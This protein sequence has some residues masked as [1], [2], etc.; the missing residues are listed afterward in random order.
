MTSKYFFT[1]AL[2]GG[3]ASLASLAQVGC[4]GSSGNTATGGGTTS[5][6]TL[7]HTTST[8]S[9]TATGGGGAGGGSTGH[10][11]ST[12]TPI[13]ENSS[14]MA[15]L[16]DA[17]TSDWYTFDGKAGDRLYLAAQATQLQTEKTGF[18]ATVTQTTMVLTGADMNVMMPLTYQA[19]EWPQFGQDAI[20]Y[21][22]LPADGAY[23]LGVQDCNGLFSSGCNP[24]A[25]ITS[26]D[27][28]L[29]VALTSKL[30]VP[31][32]VAAATNTG[33]TANADTLT[34]KVASGTQYYPS[35]FGGDFPASAGATQVFSFTPPTAS[36]AAA[37]ARSRAEFYVQP[38]GSFQG[39]DLSAA[40]VTIWA[41]DSSG[42]KIISQA[43]QVNYPTSSTAY[44]PLEFSLPY[45][46]GNQYYIF[47]KDDATPASAMTDFYFIDHYL[48]PLI[49]VAE[50]ECPTCQGTNDTPAT[51]QGLTGQ[52][53][54]KTLFTVDG[55]I[56]APATASK[57][58][59]DW[60]SFPVPNG[61]TQY[62][63]QCDSM[64]TGSGVGGFEI[65]LFS[66]AAAMA[67]PIGAN[68]ASATETP[69]TD[70]SSGNYAA[71]PSGVTTGSTMYMQL[72]GA[73]QSA[74]VTGTQY[75]CYVFFQ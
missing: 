72:T 75:R 36:A 39:G 6:H 62:A 21:V 64:R 7:T 68:F 10:D 69:T 50:A 31:E 25:D 9:A 52:G 46:A 71:L 2:I 8:T 34:Y 58:D 53:T 43:D 26:F 47:V 65:Q 12:A 48:N 41:T 28:T 5:T 54:T 23:Y 73:T 15:T 42:T 4:G 44:T 14:T 55:S 61:V 3:G 57:P 29:T 17:M 30:T 13:V 16:V 27:Y 51:A 19:G 49:D 67:S 20:L 33:M 74:T 70:I 1:L 22:Q 60:F 63:Y 24:V 66:S 32:T 59:V 40:N 38:K 11:P 56:S 35:S 37:G 18:D 45:T